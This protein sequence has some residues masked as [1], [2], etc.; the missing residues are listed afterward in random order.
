MASGWSVEQAA[1]LLG[2]SGRQVRALIA[3]GHLPA[4]RLGSVWLLDPDVVR[5]RARQSAPAG[6][7]F[8]PAFAWEV[9][10]VVDALCVADSA[11]RP[12]PQVWEDIAE[13]RM[14]HRLREVLAEPRPASRWRQALSSR[15]RRMPIWLHPGVVGR[16]AEDPRLRLGGSAAA[17]SHLVEAAGSEPR[18]WYVD[19]HDLDAVVR[20]HR[21]KA[22]GG[23][24]FDLMVIPSAVPFSRRPRQGEPVSLA[25]SLVDL[26]DSSDARERHAAQR[27]LEPLQLA[28]Q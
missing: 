21:M 6:R 28:M 12:D 24:P 7:P 5:A 4:Q 13:R 18:R 23:S 2:V 11:G 16:L 8:A 3:S 14:R 15:A 27:R 26:L 9:L 17:A 22:D 25:V 1:E 20:K 19:A 10:R